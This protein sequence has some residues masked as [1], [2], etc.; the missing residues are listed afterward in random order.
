[1]ILPHA[2]QSMVAEPDKPSSVAQRLGRGHPPYP[3]MLPAR[4]GADAPG[5][6]TAIGPVA[7]LLHH[8]TALFCSAHTPGDAILRAH[9]AARRMRDEGVTVISGFHSPIEQECLRI[10][11]R[12]KQ[13]IIVCPA[14]AIETMRIP[15][16]CRAAFDAGRLLF[17]SP[18]ATEPR[19]VT[20]ESAARRNELVAALADAAYIPHV[21]PSGQTARI[22]EMLAAWNVPLAPK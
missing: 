2:L 3:D 9:D 11:L 14:R 13:P 17:L 16:E 18:F 20:K 6:L 22:A 1:M 4:L 12:G 7:L 10:L 15:S 5:A 21:S 19:R 8:R